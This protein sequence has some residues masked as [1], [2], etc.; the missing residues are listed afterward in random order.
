M[1]RYL[2]AILVLM[3]VL[4]LAV[5]S[6]TSQVLAA[7]PSE[8]WVD[9]DFNASTPDWGTTHFDKIQDGIDAVA[10]PGT[11]H[12]AAGIYYENIIL[13]D[14]VDVL[15]VGADV[16]TIDGNRNKC[17]VAIMADNSILHGFRITGGNL[18]ECDICFFRCAIRSMDDVHTGR[19]NVEITQNI[20]EGNCSALCAAG[21]NMLLRSN[22]ILNNNEA[23]CELLTLTSALI[24][25]N[26]FVGNGVAI[27]LYR[28]FSGSIINNTIVEN[29][30]GIE[31]SG[32]TSPDIRNNIIAGSI[33]VG[34]N[35]APEPLGSPTLYNND[36]WSNGIDY[37]NIV[38]G[39]GDISADPLFVNP[40][41]DDYRLQA[42]S[43]CIDAGTNMGAPTEDIEG[44]PRPIDG[45]GDT[46]DVT[47]M[48][49][50]EYMP[51]EPPPPG[52]VEVGGEV[53]PAN[54]LSIFVTWIALATIIIAGA[55]LAVK[56]QIHS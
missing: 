22:L 24:E 39:S 35:N 19:V 26:V 7:P 21:S 10:S 16:T 37:R 55:I 56:R 40:A 45:D 34:I 20:I 27:D 48:G 53:Y 3:L 47:D 28:L 41:V 38:P 31:M 25:N 51:P 32:G 8:V 15:G 54:K 9:D 5:T 13:K 44:N 4:V 33:H 18:D 2:G 1:K 42:S 11:V 50:Y 30:N 17:P 46:I 49:A 43:P 36:V 52:E 12:V 6:L 29:G 14:G 23:G